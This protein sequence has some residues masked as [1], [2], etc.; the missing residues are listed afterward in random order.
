GDAS[1]LQVTPAALG[2]HSIEAR[3]ASFLR[4]L[5]RQ[6]PWGWSQPPERNIDEYAIDD[7][8]S[9]E[10]VKQIA[11]QY[12]VTAD[13]EEPSMPSA[14]FADQT[15]DGSSVTVA[16]AS[17]PEGGFVAIHDSSLLDGNVLG[18]VVGVSEKLDAGTHSDV[19]VHLYADVPGQDFGGQS[20]LEED[21]TLIAMPH[22]DTNGNG[23]YDFVSS[24]GEADGPY[25]KDGQPVVADAMITVE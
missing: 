14:M 21:Q 8:M 17:L 1:K 20:S 2:I 13:D 6:R 19:M 15:S 7:P 11:S 18:S 24:G 4:T 23:T 25:T 12:I 3:H 10:E 16:S 9:M 22:Y 5:K